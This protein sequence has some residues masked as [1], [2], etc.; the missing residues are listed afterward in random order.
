MFEGR[1]FVK[2]VGTAKSSI[3][4]EHLR[5][6]INRFEK[7]NYFN[8]RGRYHD[9]EDGCDEFVTDHPSANTS[10]RINGKSRACTTI[11]VAEA[12]KCLKNLRNSSRRSTTRS[13]QLNGYV[14][15]SIK[16]LLLCVY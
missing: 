1:R 4:Q 5:E 8:L 9:P 10:I 7:I 11:T 3:S 14:S 16:E 13:T 6:L 12:S 2:K 15:E